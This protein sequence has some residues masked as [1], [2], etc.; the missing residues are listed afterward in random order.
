MCSMHVLYACVHVLYACV[1][2]LYA[3]ACMLY[4]VHVRQVAYDK[5]AIS[6]SI[7]FRACASTLNV[8]LRHTFILAQPHNK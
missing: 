1:H 4:G 6:L 2:V 3:C 5:K 7:S 8:A